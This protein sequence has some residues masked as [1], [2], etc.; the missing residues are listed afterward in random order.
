MLR[1]L[2]WPSGAISIRIQ[3][4][5]WL[6][7]TIAITGC[8]APYVEPYPAR[9]ARP[10]DGDVVLVE[11]NLIIFDASGS[12]DRLVDFPNEKAVLEAFLAGMPPGTYRVA[13]RVLGG[14][15]DA[16]VHLATFD[17]FEL[18]Q[19]ARKVGWTGRQ[20]PLAQVLDDYREEFATRAGR[21]AVIVFTDGVPT[22]Y[23]KY[24]GPEET[25][26]AARRLHAR[27]PG[28]LCY[29]TVQ[30]GMD[31]RGPALL[32][33]MAELGEC[34]SFRTIDAL[35]GADA[36]HAFQMQIYN[37]PPPP[38][39]AKRARAMTDLDG[40]GVDD[41]FDRCARTPAGAK[42]DERG[43]WVIEDYVFDHDQA[44]IRPQHE[45]TLEAVVRVLAANPGVRVR[46]DGH[47]DATGA[48]AYNFDLGKR[49]AE[50]LAV[51]LIDHGIDA[52]RLEVHSFGPGRP[53]APNDTQQ[54]RRKNRRVELS[55]IDF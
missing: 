52:L 8:A 51:W 2:G 33:G 35:D 25:V 50:A 10:T 7:I 9:L 42:V 38:I 19:H 11:D 54:G 46:L 53:V 31:P 23:G 6:A 37:G 5:T 34:G 28:E 36:L 22:R 48:A 15:E 26:E 17:R 21:V 24:I 13:L 39:V 47:T 20:T 29:H 30:V 49:R 41:R 14:R 55:I 40:D 3:R 45:A 43:C 4:A 18:R 27:H 32:R 44:T 12:I 16:Q 1:A